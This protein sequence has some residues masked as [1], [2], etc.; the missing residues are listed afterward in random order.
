MAAHPGLPRGR[1]AGRYG[2]LLE[3]VRQPQG[4][5]GQPAG[6]GHRLLPEQAPDAL[7]RVGGDLAARL[8]EDHRPAPR[9]EILKFDQAAF[10]TLLQ[11]IAEEGGAVAHGLY[12]A[13]L[14]VPGFDEL[15]PQALL[16][17]VEAV[18]VEIDLAAQVVLEVGG[19]AEGP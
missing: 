3:R 19:Q 18:Q 16:H 15:Q 7:Y 5:F 2:R 13:L 17:F 9:V 4:V 12:V 10:E 6:L 11:E 8:L 14:V 1:A